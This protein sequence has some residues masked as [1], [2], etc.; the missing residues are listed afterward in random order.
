MAYE[1]TGVMTITGCGANAGY[2]I[3][4]S[5][6]FAEGS[7]VY[8]CQKAS[9]QGIIEAVSIR[10]VFLNGGNQ[11]IPIYLDSYNTTYAEDELCSQSDAIAAAT[12]YWNNLL[13]ET[14]EAINILCG[15]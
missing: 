2:S 11:Y 6:R 12:A 7:T 3:C 15:N 13:E 8:L 10:K 5:F 4:R 14:N 1:A 9:A